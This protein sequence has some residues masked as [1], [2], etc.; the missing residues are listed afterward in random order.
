MGEERWLDEESWP[1]PGTATRIL[2]LAADGSL[3]ARRPGPGTRSFIDDPE[4]PVPT[5]G[6]ANL[7][8]RLRAG[9]HD[10]REVEA[11]DDVVVYSTEPLEEPVAACGTARVVLTAASD[12]LDTNL[13]VRLT[14]VRPDGR[15]MLVGDSIARASLRADTARQVPIVPGQ[16]YEVEVRLPPTAI[17]FLP[18]HR[19]RIS[20]SG[21]NWPRFERNPH[22][23]ADH[24]DRREAVPA[25]TT[26]HH[27][28]DARS[29]LELP[30]RGEA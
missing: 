19:I 29:F 20:V 9:P 30:V 17:T 7:P 3:V 16:L 4:N 18:G 2:H 5:R 8:V 24:Y 21:T 12:A 13:A 6:G 28:G 10:Q 15:S 26:L 11:R 27:G 25:T 1:P 14:D 23:G 22:T